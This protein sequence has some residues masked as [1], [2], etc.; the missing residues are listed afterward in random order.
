M[1]QLSEKEIEK[2]IDYAKDILDDLKFEF[3]PVGST[4]VVLDQVIILI[5]QIFSRIKDLEDS[6]K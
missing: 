4:S 5:E 2:I 6:K 3:G 1:N